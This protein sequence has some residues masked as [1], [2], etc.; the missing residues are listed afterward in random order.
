[1][2]LPAPEPDAADPLLAYR[3]RFPIVSR[4]NYLI[5]NPQDVAGEA[6]GVG[7]LTAER[8]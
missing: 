4:T 3:T 8:S 2:T 5:S 6:T 1:V 7:S